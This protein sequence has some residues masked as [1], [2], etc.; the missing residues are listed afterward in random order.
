MIP[1]FTYPIPF[2]PNTGPQALSSA[3]RPVCAAVSALASM[4]SDGAV[5]GGIARRLTPEQSRTAL[6]RYLHDEGVPQN[7]VLSW[8]NCLH[9]PRVWNVNRRFI[10]LSVDGLVL[11]EY[12]TYTIANTTPAG[13]VLNLGCGLGK[14]LPT[15]ALAIA[16]ASEN[17]EKSKRCWIVCPVNAFGAWRRFVPALKQV[18]LDVQIISMDSLHKAVGCANL[19]GVIIFDEVHLLGEPRARRTK[20]AHIV[21]NT[22]DCGF[23]LTGTMNHGGIHKSLSILDLAIP[24]AS[25]FGNLWRC[26]EYFRCLIKKKLGARTVTGLARPVG[27]ARELFFEFMGRHTITMTKAS[28]IVRR[29]IQFPDQHLH[30]IEL[31]DCSIPLDTLAADFVRA[32]IQEHGKIPEASAVA[33][34]LARAGVDEKLDYL[35]TEMDPPGGESV[36]IFAGYTES[37]DAAQAML[38]E[39]GYTFVRV[40]GSVTG[41]DRIEAQRK[42]QAGEAQV[43]LG[44]EHAAGISMD[45]FRSCISVT[46][47]FNWSGADYAQM[48]ARTCRRGQ[49][50]VC[51]HL[52][53]VTNK[54]QLTV[55]KKLREA[56][57]F[58]AQ[59]V[60]YNDIQRALIGAYICQPTSSP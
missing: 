38:I 30:T 40:D 1:A 12:Q 39:N 44:Q 51:H 56:E 50:D 28:E 34:V 33:H 60:E 16:I 35:L 17:P 8:A 13:A 6:V 53:L 29:E 36:A 14:T 18:F 3:D 52:D 27:P 2:L 24:G 31:G 57:N 41:K 22:F 55:L 19:G 21:R 10:P 11:S 45:L 20:S 42:F 26:G 48:L 7:R 25:W 46:L 58:D 59:C 43:F 32:Y 54:F 15:A 23:C 5:L 49:T 9:D 4:L 37:L 47:D